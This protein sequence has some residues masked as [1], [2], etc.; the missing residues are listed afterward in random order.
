MP[1]DIDSEWMLAVKVQVLVYGMEQWDY[2]Q[3]NPTNQDFRLISNKS[4]VGPLLVCNSLLKNGPLQTRFFV[5]LGPGGGPHS[6]Q[7]MGRN[8]TRFAGQN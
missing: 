1:E 2:V 8:G 3:A 6:F 4:N 5:V 7:K